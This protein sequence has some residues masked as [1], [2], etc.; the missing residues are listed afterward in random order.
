MAVVKQVVVVWP[1]LLAIRA[2]LLR[3]GVTIF[4]KRCCTISQTSFISL[5]TRRLDDICKE[6]LYYFPDFFSLYRVHYRLRTHNIGTRT[7]IVSV[8]ISGESTSLLTQ[9]A[10]YTYLEGESPET[11]PL[12]IRAQLGSVMTNTS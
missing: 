6:V 3:A 5:S 4:V 10:K 7:I 2:H 9:D 1:C 12:K 8:R 11:K